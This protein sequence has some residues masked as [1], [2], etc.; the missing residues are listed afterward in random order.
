METKLLR[1]VGEAIRNGFLNIHRAYHS[2]L[3]QHGLTQDVLNDWSENIDEG[4]S[5]IIIASRNDISV[6]FFIPLG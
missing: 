5:L 6:I 1:R 4:T 2:K 3:L